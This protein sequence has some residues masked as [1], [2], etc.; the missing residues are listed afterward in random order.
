MMMAR[1]K[2]R[3]SGS[4]PSQHRAI[5]QVQVPIVGAGNGER[6]HAAFPAP[7]MRDMEAV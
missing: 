3:L 1:A 6:V 2:S 4:T 7:A 5:A